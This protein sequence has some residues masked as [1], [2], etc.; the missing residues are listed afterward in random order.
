MCTY[1]DMAAASYQRDDWNPKRALVQSWHIWSKQWLNQQRSRKMWRVSGTLAAT[2][3]IV[4][5][6]GMLTGLLAMFGVIF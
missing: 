3:L 1:A 2:G 5:V 6:V 4:M